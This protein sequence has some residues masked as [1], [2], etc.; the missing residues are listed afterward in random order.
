VNAAPGDKGFYVVPFRRY[1]DAASPVPAVTDVFGVVATGVHLNPD[2]IGT[3]LVEAVFS[4]VLE[5]HAAAAL[6]AATDQR[7]SLDNLLGIASPE[8]RIAVDKPAEVFASLAA[9]SKVAHYKAAEY[10]ARQVFE[11]W[12]SGFN[13]GLSHLASILGNLVRAI[14]EVTFISGPFF[15]AQKS[16]VI[17]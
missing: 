4:D 12:V 6:D 5:P 2:P 13:V 8:G 7:G 17:H 11:K 14:G 1:V 16:E 9:A 3:T 10:L 15:I